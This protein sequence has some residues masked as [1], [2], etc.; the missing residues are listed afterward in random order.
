MYISLGG[1]NAGARARVGAGAR[2]GAQKTTNVEVEVRVLLLLMGISGAPPTSSSSPASR[3]LWQELLHICGPT[4]LIG[5]LVVLK[6][7]SLL[8]LNKLA[9]LLDLKLLEL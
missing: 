2:V 5:R 4:I 3:G 8:F 1:T 6:D 9:D 7:K